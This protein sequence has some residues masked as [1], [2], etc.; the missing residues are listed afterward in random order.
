M[1]SF[2]LHPKLRSGSKCCV[3]LTAVDLC[4]L[5]FDLPTQL[6]LA[7]LRQ[8]AISKT[9][10]L[11]AVFPSFRLLAVI[12]STNSI[13]SLWIIGEGEVVQTRDPRQ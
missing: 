9:R 6:R 10:P 7:S 4:V 11:S 3:A 1:C 13:Q 5:L 8:S 12:V 2:P